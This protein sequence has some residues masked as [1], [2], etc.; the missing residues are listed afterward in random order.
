MNLKF[1]PEAKVTEWQNGPLYFKNEG[2][3]I[4]AKPSQ[5][6][7]MLR[8]MHEVQPQQFV[9]IF[10]VADQD[11]PK[12]KKAIHELTVDY[13]HDFPHTDKLTK[14]GLEFDAVRILNKEQLVA[15]EGIGPASADA[16]LAALGENK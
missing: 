2:D 10:V 12:T 1:N 11:K 7:A 5:A 3:A 9:N 14:A 8:A 16:I 13:P 15:V 4:E 6:R